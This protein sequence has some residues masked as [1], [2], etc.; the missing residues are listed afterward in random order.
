MVFRTAASPRCSR[1]SHLAEATLL[2]SPLCLF[3]SKHHKLDSN[4]QKTLVA[5]EWVLTEAGLH[6]MRLV[7]LRSATCLLVRPL[8]F[9][10]R[11]HVCMVENRH[12]DW[13]PGLDDSG[14][15]MASLIV[16]LA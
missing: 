11:G 8:L 10:Q 15:N 13:G 14:A 16:L 12:F 1:I 2:K 3:G 4:P 7:L 9:S 6:E 5:L